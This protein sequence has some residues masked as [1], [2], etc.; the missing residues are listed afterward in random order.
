[1]NNFVIIGLGILILLLVYIL[2]VYYYRSANAITPKQISLLNSNPYID[3]STIKNPASVNF[4]YGAWIYVNTWSSN[5]KTLFYLSGNSSVRSGV[6]LYATDSATAS[7]PDF[8]V[9]LDATDPKLYCTMGTKSDGSPFKVLLTNNF[10]IQKWTYVVVSVDGKIMDCYLDG[11]LVVSTQLDSVTSYNMTI[12]N[13]AKDNI[14]LGDCDA[15]NKNDIFITMLNRWDHPLD[16][17]TVWQNYL[18]GNGTGTFASNYKV[19]L[20]VSNN[21]VKESSLQLF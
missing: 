21:D 4:A 10:P 15:S 12:S 2:Y 6:N 7:F 3:N 13:L 8:S 14:Y 5:R 20:Q 9:G 19:E 18:N 16:P 17:K 11:K 1:M